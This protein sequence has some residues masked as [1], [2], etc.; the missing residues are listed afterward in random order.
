[1]PHH[2]RHIS[3]FVV[4]RTFYFL[5]DKPVRV[6]RK[7]II[8]QNIPNKFKMIKT[9]FHQDKLISPSTIKKILFRFV[10]VMII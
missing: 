10:R 7:I 6:G 8:A 9:D 2:T 5:K 4:C 3:R 1:M